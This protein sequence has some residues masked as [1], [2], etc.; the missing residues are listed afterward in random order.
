M[1]I[2][3]HMEAVFIAAVAVAAAT[4]IATAAV[5][6]ATARCGRR[7]AVGRPDAGRDHRRQAP[8]RSGKSAS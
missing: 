1:N 8:H 6:A 4:G 5:P 2:A 7:R 3:K